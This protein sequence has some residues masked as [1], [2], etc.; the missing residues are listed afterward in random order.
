MAA[1]MLTIMQNTGVTV[2]DPATRR[3]YQRLDL[4][5]ALDHVFGDKSNP[6]FE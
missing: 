5:G 4:A 1:A 2:D 6:A 3:S